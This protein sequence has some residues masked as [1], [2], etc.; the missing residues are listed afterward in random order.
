MEFRKV[1]PFDYDQYL[2]LINDF[3]TTTFTQSEFEQSLDIIS[4]SSDII[5]LIVDNQI[6]G[7]A[8]IIYEHK[9]IFNRCILCHIEDVCIK[10]EFRLKKY[11]SQLIE[12]CV[13]L[14][15]KNGAYKVS[16][17]CSNENVAFYQS[18]SFDKRGNQ[19]TILF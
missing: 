12:Y 4:K 2:S 11:G 8:T 16:L 9:L 6:I 14:C 15:K 7:T 17:N 19:M 3:R 1:Q 10:K 13:Q 5:I 18:C